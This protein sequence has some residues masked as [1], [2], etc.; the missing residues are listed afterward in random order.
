MLHS[1]CRA[2]VGD[3]NSSAPCWLTLDDL[4]VDPGSKTSAPCWLTLDDLV[5]GSDDSKNAP[6]STANRPVEVVQQVNDSLPNG[7]QQEAAAQQCAEQ[8]QKAKLSIATRKP[9]QKGSKS[10]RLSAK[11]HTSGLIQKHL[12][13]SVWTPPCIDSYSAH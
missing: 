4:N 5:V 1:C 11:L 9:K 2:V 13:K 3:A 8:P 10:A 6:V 12:K 7:C